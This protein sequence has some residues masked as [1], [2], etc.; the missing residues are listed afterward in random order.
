[1]K[2]SNI[3]KSVY[4]FF[5]TKLKGAGITDLTIVPKWP[6]T[7]QELQIPCLSLEVSSFIPSD[8]YELGG[9]HNKP[10]RFECNLFVN[11]KFDRDNI[12]SEIHNIFNTYTAISLMDYEQEPE[13]KIGLLYIKNLSIDY[14][15]VYVFEDVA[16]ERA[17]ITFEVIQIE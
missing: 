6:E 11:D 17:L 12:C 13:V 14:S 15:Y 4:N 10:T 3:K 16:K 2:I 9:K 8:E 1:M 7:E 5:D